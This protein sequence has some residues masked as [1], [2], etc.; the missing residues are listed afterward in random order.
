MHPEQKLIYKS[1]SPDR[2]FA[3]AME[4]YWTARRAREGWLRSL[5]PHWTEEQIRRRVRDIFLHAGN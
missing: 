2:K 4:L 3:I 5:H 1:M